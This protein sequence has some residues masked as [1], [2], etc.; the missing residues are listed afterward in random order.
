MTI[1]EQQSNVIADGLV[2]K[3]YIVLKDILP[4]ELTLALLKRVE[5]ISNLQEAKIGRGS[6][7]QQVKSIRSD[8][9]LWLEGADE[10]EQAYLEWMESLCVEMNRSLYMGLDCYEAHFAKYEAG[11]LYQ[12]HLDVLK[13]ENKRLLTTVFYLNEHWQEGDGGELLIYEKS[14]NEPLE[15]VE[16]HLGVMVIF[17]SDRF[18][19]EVLKANSTRY[20]IAG[21]FKGV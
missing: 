13:G 6:E 7:R 10:S 19:H 17:L 5:G 12:K 9:T 14:E 11:A 15:K 2:E 4:K 21:W 20:S 18:P 16:P 3:G 8:K 1:S